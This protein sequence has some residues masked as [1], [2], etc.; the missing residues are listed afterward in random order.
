MTSNVAGADG[1]PAGTSP[2]RSSSPWG[3]LAT[4]TVQQAAALTGLSEHTLRYYERIGLIQPV[5][6]PAASALG[7]ARKQTIHES[8]VDLWPA[9]YARPDGARRADVPRQHQRGRRCGPR[10]RLSARTAARC[11]GG[12]NRAGARL[13]PRAAAR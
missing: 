11:A 2:P 5:A 9:R 1:A 6:E 7:R 12:R 10:A 13:R 4:Y 8:N 3:L